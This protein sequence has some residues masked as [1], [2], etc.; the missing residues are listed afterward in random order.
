M[1]MVDHPF[2]AWLYWNP[3]RDLFTIPFLDHPVRIY[4][5]CFVTGFIIGYFLLAAMFKQKILHAN[6]ITERDISSWS[7]LIKQLQLAFDRPEHKIAPLVQKLDKKARSEIQ[8][9]KCDQEPCPKL[10]AAILYSINNAPIK[11]TRATL[12]DLLPDAFITAKQWG[13]TLTDKLTWY[14]VL[15]TIIGARLGDVF[16]YDWPHYKDNL[17]RIFMVWKGGLASHGGVLG[18]FIAVYLYYRKVLKSFPEISFLNLLDMLVVPSGLAAF[19]IRIGNFFNQEILG[20]ETHMPWGIIFGDPIDGSPA[21]PRHPTQLYEA[22]IYLAIFFTTLF[23][24]KTRFTKLKPGFL[25]GFFFVAVFGSRFLI[26]FIKMPQSQLIDESFLQ[27]GQ[28]LSIPFIVFG[29]WLMAFGRHWNACKC[30][31]YK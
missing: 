18:V 30:T 31:P 10:K 17:L 20:P 12:E 24:W 16:F 9:L 13:Y 2:I 8:Q 6:T 28:Y 21:I 15:G 5:V 14:V 1:S 27:M 29:I 19:F 25:C 4:G 23:L 3:S 11:F 22:L 7:T 26:E